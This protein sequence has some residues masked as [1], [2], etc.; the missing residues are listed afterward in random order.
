MNGGQKL[1]SKNAFMALIYA[2]SLLK[3]AFGIYYASLTLHIYTIK[4][5]RLDHIT[6][7]KKYRSTAD[8]FT[9]FPPIVRIMVFLNFYA[10]LGY[11]HKNAS[12]RHC[13]QRFLDQF[14][15]KGMHLLVVDKKY[16][17]FH[18]NPFHV[19]IISKGIKN[20]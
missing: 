11:R 14:R 16:I 6:H 20:H 1:A 2:I 13:W 10:V 9:F 7:N 4:T 12:K 18:S 17:R 8:W 15:R 3:R 5:S 19:A